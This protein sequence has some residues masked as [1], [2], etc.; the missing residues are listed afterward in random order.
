MG[1]RQSVSQ[2][3]KGHSA[4]DFKRK[5]LGRKQLALACAAVIATSVALGQTQPG[6]AASSAEFSQA[7]AWK[8]LTNQCDMGIRKPG[9][10]GQKECRDYIE[11][12]LKK[13]CDSV[14]LQPFQHVWSTNGQNLQFWNVIGEQNWKNSTVHVLLVTH[15]DTRPTADQETDPAKKLMPIMGADDGASGTAV[16]LELARALHVS[17]AKVG[18][19]YLFVDGEDLGPD[20]PDMYLGAKVFAKDPSS[21]KPDYGILLD[22]IGNKNVRVPEEQNSLTLCPKLESAFYDFAGEAGYG[23]T[24]PKVVSWQIEDD[25]LALINGKIPTIDLID[26]DYAPWHTLADTVDKCSPE[27]L[28]KIGGVLEKWLRKPKPFALD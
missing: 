5:A 8:D 11:A 17:P 3:S 28:G 10:P 4:R 20:E 26:F 19:K 23:S 18:V 12:E 1:R 14:Y 24:F 6:P 15:W 2:V 13:S 21:P 27:S 22:M 7:R 25:H 16:M 9:T